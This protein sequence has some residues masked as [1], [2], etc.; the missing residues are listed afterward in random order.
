MGLEDWNWRLPVE[1]QDVPWDC[2]AASLTWCLNSIGRT[3]TE[4]DVVAGLGPAR[5]SPAY[6]LLDASGAGLV[7]YLGE[8]G[9]GAANNPNAS[10]EDVYSAA[11]YQ[12][13][14]IGGRGWCH[15]SGVR[16]AKLIEPYSINSFLA[17]ANPAPGWDSVNQFLGS[18]DFSRLGTF[19]AVWFTSW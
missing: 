1:L 9:I 7:E 5:I 15:W 13:M 18:Y 6:G 3:E 4:A 17:L 14:L 19:S 11:G 8:L 12:P 2:A 10:F 16:I